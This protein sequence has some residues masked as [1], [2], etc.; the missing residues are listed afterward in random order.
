[1][2]LEGKDVIGLAETGSGKTAAFALPILQGMSISTLLNPMLLQLKR[3]LALMDK[4]QAL[5]G[6]VLAPTRELAY[7]ISQAFEALVCNTM[8]ASQNRSK[9]LQGSLIAV[10]CTVLVGGMGEEASIYMLDG[11]NLHCA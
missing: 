6:L 7:Q 8:C 5:F 11:Q 3:I 4:P 9:C 10:R 2:A 1:M